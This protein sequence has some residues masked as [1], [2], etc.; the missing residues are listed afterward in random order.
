[1]LC[2]KAYSFFE[3]E[4][5]ASVEHRYS[6]FPYEFAATVAAVLKA[7]MKRDTSEAVPALSR[8]RASAPPP[9]RAL[10]LK[11]RVLKGILTAASAPAWLTAAATGKRACLNTVIVRRAG[12]T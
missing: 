11:T 4:D 1:M 12:S 2:A 10:S 6:E 7:K 9:L 8:T 5:V 3:L